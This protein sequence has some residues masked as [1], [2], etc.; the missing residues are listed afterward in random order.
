MHYALSRYLR[1]CR[2]VKKY[3]KQTTAPRKKAK[4]KAAAKTNQTQYT[5]KKLGF[6]KGKFENGKA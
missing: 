6:L 4:T 2:T 1:T 3:N 5:K